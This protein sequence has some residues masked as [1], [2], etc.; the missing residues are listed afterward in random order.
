M[1]K[2]ILNCNINSGADRYS[3]IRYFLPV[4]FFHK[5]DFKVSNID[6]LRLN[7][8]FVSTKPQLSHI[9]IKRGQIE[10][11]FVRGCGCDLSGVPSQSK[12]AAEKMRP[13][14]RR[15]FLSWGRAV[16]HERRQ[17]K[18]PRS[19]GCGLCYLS[20]RAYRAGKLCG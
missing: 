10:G 2:D 19:R 9:S 12:K 1:S 16:R 6:N 11:L 15:G 3:P 20:G 4:N 7:V 18:N 13:G 17:L 8:H 5:N 14:R